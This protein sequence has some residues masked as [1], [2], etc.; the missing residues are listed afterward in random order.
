MKRIHE[1]KLIHLRGIRYCGIG[2]LYEESTENVYFLSI[3]PFID[4]CNNMKDDIKGEV[5][6]NYISW[7]QIRN[8]SV[9]LV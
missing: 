7:N 9:I 8:Q 5:K 4:I 6:N 3:F 1:I 2:E